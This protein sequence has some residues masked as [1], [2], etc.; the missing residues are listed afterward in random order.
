[1]GVP[2]GGVLLGGRLSVGSS[3][4]VLLAYGYSKIPPF[5]GSPVG[6]DFSIWVCAYALRQS[7]YTYPAVCTKRYFCVFPAAGRVEC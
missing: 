1:M 5:G 3:S 4:F 7:V 2:V 6:V